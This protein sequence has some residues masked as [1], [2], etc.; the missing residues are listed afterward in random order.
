[1]NEQ[2][3]QKLTKIAA[4]LASRGPRQIAPQTLEAV[5]EKYGVQRP[6]WK[7]TPP[8]RKVTSLKPWLKGCDAVSR[9][10][11][12]A[13]LEGTSVALANS[14]GGDTPSGEIGAPGTMIRGGVIRVDPSMRMSPYLA[15]GY[16]GHSGIYEELLREP[17]VYQASTSIKHV[18]TSADW[19]MAY[20]ASVP[21][22]MR[23]Q[24]EEAG[25]WAWGMLLNIED[26]WPQYVEDALSA[27][28]FGFS[29]FEIVWRAADAKQRVAIRRLAY[30]E[31][32]TVQEW[33]MSARGREL[34]GA[35][36]QSGGDASYTYALPAFGDALEDHRL[37]VN[38]LAGRGNNFEGLPPVRT[39]EP[40][41]TLK[42]LLIQIIGVTAERFGAP[43]LTSRVDSALVGKL[44][45]FSVNE[46]DVD[47]FLDDL[48]ELLAVDTATLSVPTGLLLEYV[49]A[50][51]E[52]PKWV[53][54]LQYID[55]QIAIAF[56]TQG[57]LLGQQGVGSHALSQTQDDVFLRA[58]PYYAQCV[59]KGLNKLLRRIFRAP[60]FNLRLIE[61]PQV[62]WRM[63]AGQDPTTWLTS[64]KT[65][66][67][68][69][70]G[71][72]PEVLKAAL[73][74]LDLSPDAYND[75]AA[76]E[77]KSAGEDQQRV[78][79]ITNALKSG[80]VAR[81]PDMV[82]AMHQLLDM[83]EPTDQQIADL[84]AQVVPGAPQDPSVVDPAEV[85]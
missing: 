78:Y 10:E 62:A 12:T 41:I 79:K 55:T 25:D 44:A 40:I 83:P 11:L 17:I 59:T 7:A 24:V 23:E 69:A 54:V 13:A 68:I 15:R 8:L 57:A 70:L 31:Q 29:P 43:I 46:E 82:R 51:G 49:G 84:L 36:F 37:L 73:E 81:T 6:A 38:T 35:R 64:V 22:E 33:L 63:G 75:L 48:M 67:E 16:A 18:L 1:M 42:H 28:D 56:S 77:L 58:A 47:A 32:S 61:Y 45:G 80:L 4:L 5:Y 9:V 34:L 66:H 26:G 50:A 39:V 27:V 14:L 71:L 85:A 72:P 19:H 52:M 53:D 76:Q 65:L 2:R 20:P 60:P 30:R 21:E 3:L 74:K